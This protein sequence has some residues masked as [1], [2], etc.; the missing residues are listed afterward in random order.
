MHRLVGVANMAIELGL[1][2]GIGAETERPGIEV[3]RL[4]L[5]LV[6]VDGSAIEPARRAGLETGQVKADRSQ[7]VAQSFRG[8]VPCP[9]PSGLGLAHVHERL[10]EGPRR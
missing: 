6:E 4:W 3:A 10:E 5:Q 9:A 2:D 8:A 7:A 1:G